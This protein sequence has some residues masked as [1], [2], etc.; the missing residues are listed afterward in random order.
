MLSLFRKE[1]VVTLKETDTGLSV[2]HHYNIAPELV[3][4]AW[5]DADA[6]R[7]F[8]FKTPDGEMGRV[9]IDGRVGGT[10]TIVERRDG[11]DTL[12]TGQYLEI[13]RPQRLVFTFS[14]PQYSKIETKVSLD[15][16]PD[17]GGCDVTLTHENVLPE[18]K[19]RTIEGWKKILKTLENVL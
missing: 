14:V 17:K 3:F 19:E 2:H 4:D 10:F 11:Q 15:F 6:A 8:L 1:M 12:H 13:K 7:K 9:D 16:V 18:W 5:L